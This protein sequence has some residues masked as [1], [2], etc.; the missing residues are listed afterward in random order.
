[1]RHFADA[2]ANHNLQSASQVGRAILLTLTVL[3]C[4]DVPLTADEDPKEL[5]KA[6]VEE[7]RAEFQEYDFRR[8]AITPT[9]LTMESQSLLNWSNPE[10]GAANGALFLWT[11][12]GRPQMIVCAFEWN[13]I[14]KHEF[15]SLSVDPITA[16]RRGN[17]VHRF[18]P[19]VEFKELPE[20]PAPV[21]QRALRLAQMRRLAERFR[22]TMGKSETRL[23]TQPVFRSPA[24]LS[25]DIAIFVFVQGTDPE[26]TLLLEAADMKEWR[27][28]LARQS[29]WGLKVE[30][31]QKLVWEVAPT[32]KAQAD[33]PFFVAPQKP[34]SSG[35]R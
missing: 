32:A 34:A 16:Q 20:A 27:Y 35:K 21:S 11:D 19:G 9:S 15:H 26:C 17:P 28:A 22:V 10:R 25:D 7:R 5:A 14:L 1:V 31:D 2:A 4:N 29:K 6:W 3:I 12:Q 8:E 23:L 30:L 18:A 24:A 13:G 33:A